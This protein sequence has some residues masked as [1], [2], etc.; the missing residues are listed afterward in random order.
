MNT[1]NT[2]SQTGK[3]AIVTGAS[4]GIGAAIAQRL[5]ADGMAVVINYAYSNKEADA[6]AA[7]IAANGGKA[8]AVKADVADPAAVAQLFDAAEAAFGK[9]DVLINNAGV[10][11][12]GLPALADTDDAAFDSIFNINVK[13]S[14]NTMRQAAKR[15]QSGGRIVNF[16]TSV[17]GL[18]LPGYSVYA[19]SKSAIETMTNIFAKE[20]RG[21]QINVNAIAPGPTATDLFLT[22]KTEEIIARLSKAAPLERLGT[23]EDIAAAVAFLVGAD[24]GW[25]NGQ[26]LRANGGIV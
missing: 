10:M 5:A 15:L 25:I 18:A 7:R 19:A 14:F 8:V 23:P 26:T 21:R 13:G 6:L 22:G 1:A 20:L 24:G 12:A 11:P 16:S 9:V 17:S 4:R 3:V 2:L